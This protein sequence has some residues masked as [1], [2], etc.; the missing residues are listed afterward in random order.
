MAELHRRISL[1]EL[2]TSFSGVYLIPPFDITGFPNEYQKN[3]H[4]IE[5]LDIRHRLTEIFTEVFTCIHTYDDDIN[6]L[7][8]RKVLPVDVATEL[9]SL[10]TKLIK[11]DENNRRLL[12]YIPFEMLPDYHHPIMNNPQLLRAQAEFKDTFRDQWFRLLFESEPRANFSDG[13]VLEPGLGEPPKVRK[14][15][16]IVPVLLEKGII[17]ETDVQIVLDS[18]SDTE[19]V[20]S[21]TEGMTA[22]NKMGFTNFL[23]SEQ[24]SPQ[25]TIAALN[26]K[27]FINSHELEHSDLLTIKSTFLEQLNEIDHL[28]RPGSFYVSKI[29]QKRAIWEKNVAS[30][31]LIEEYATE[32]GRR[33]SENIIEFQDFHATPDI[34]ISRPLKLLAIRSLVKGSE[35]HWKKDISAAQKL[36]SSAMSWIKNCWKNTDENLANE[37]IS[38]M[39]HWEKLGLVAAE[40][41]VSMDIPVVDVVC[42]QSFI[43]NLGKETPEILEMV[44]K[45]QENPRIS[46]YLYPF[47]LLVGSRVKGYGNLDS[48]I[49][50]AVCIRPHV[51][52]EKRDEVLSLLHQEIP[53]LH[54]V[55]TLEYWIDKQNGGYTLRSKSDNGTANILHAKDIHF[56]LG[57]MWIGY[58]SDIGEIYHDIL[59]KYLDLSRFGDQKEFVRFTLLR[60]LESDILQYRFMH[61]GYQKMYPPRHDSRYRD[62][63]TIDG[64]SAFWDSGY[65][66]V[67]TLLFLKKVF[68]PDITQ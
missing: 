48:D 49:D 36:V 38:A 7:L 16:H 65:R 5:Q 14:A 53:E 50:I 41:L 46:S 56:F 2:H 59:G 33:V 67:A 39:N 15:A 27:I 34:Q 12:L 58:G 62:C 8:E 23:I 24:T 4:I 3:P 66:E 9:Y 28:Y 13:D 68:L 60:K 51:P 26:K 64:E 6:G 25:P 47:I 30:D 11:Q 10:C 21:L 17:D 20:R 63:N 52:W 37:I 19:L 45:I 1:H 35:I 61:K 57:G 54:T 40:K 29:S 31:T 18:T 42:T 43:E 44:K 32:I 55:D 22:A